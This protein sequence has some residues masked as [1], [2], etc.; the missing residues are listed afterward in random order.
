MT[1][2]EYIVENY[3]KEN[4]GQTID[5]LSEEET[6]EKR[7]TEVRYMAFADYV[8]SDMYKSIKMTVGNLKARDVDIPTLISFIFDT[9][10][11]EDDVRNWIE[12]V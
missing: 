3:I 8:T 1:F 9:T 5:D 6:F 2:L 10:D 11:F 4:G 7:V 12:E